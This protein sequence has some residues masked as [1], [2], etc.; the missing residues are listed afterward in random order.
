MRILQ[1]ARTRSTRPR[2]SRSPG[3]ASLA[4]RCPAAPTAA[5][6]ARTPRSSGT[7]RLPSETGPRAERLDGRG[8]GGSRPL[9]QLRERAVDRVPANVGAQTDEDRPGELELD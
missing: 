5:A 2:R 3:S 6:T 9:D 8:A 4:A 7:H 1:R